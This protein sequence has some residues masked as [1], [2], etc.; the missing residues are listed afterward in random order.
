MIC[1]VYIQICTPKF[2]KYNMD[3]TG[4]WLNIS[5]AA[6]IEYKLFELLKV[7]HSSPSAVICRKYCSSHDKLLNK[8]VYTEDNFNLKTVKTVFSSDYLVILVFYRLIQANVNLY[9]EVV[10]TTLVN[11]LCSVWILKLRFQSYF[12]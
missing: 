2:D 7:W 1:T 4:L 10:F 9:S 8:S 5:F 6:A 11:R 3:M 12:L